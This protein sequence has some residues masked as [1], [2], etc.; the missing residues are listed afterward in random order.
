MEDGELDVGVINR[1]EGGIKGIERLW[2]EV[3]MMVEGMEGR[4]VR[5][6]K[7]SGLDGL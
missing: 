2:N 6:Y 7:R 3:V 1:E 4:K 5:G